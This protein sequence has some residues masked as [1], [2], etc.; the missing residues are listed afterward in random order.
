MGNGN[1]SVNK[2]FIGNALETL[3]IGNTSF[4]R[5][6]TVAGCDIFG[7]ESGLTTA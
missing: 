3:G 6:F 2:R 5:P 1:A 7:R 4:C